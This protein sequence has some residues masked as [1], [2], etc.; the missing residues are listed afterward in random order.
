MPQPDFILYYK[1]EVY[2]NLDLKK[3]KTDDTALFFLI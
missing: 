3:N 2:I 1:L